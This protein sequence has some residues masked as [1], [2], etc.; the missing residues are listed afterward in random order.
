MAPEPPA[1]FA[2]VASQNEGPNSRTWEPARGLVSFVV[3]RPNGPSSGP[4]GQPFPQPG[5]QALVAPANTPSGPTGQPFPQPRER[6][7]A[8]LAR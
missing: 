4:T 6:R 1:A 5:S 8:W 7:E 2:R 3:F